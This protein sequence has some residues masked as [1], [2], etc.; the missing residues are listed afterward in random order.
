[1]KG[2]GW[3]VIMLALLGVTYLVV[4]DLDVLTGER[5]GETV[6]EPL[7]HAKDTANLVQKTRDDLQKR[8]DNLDE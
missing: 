1:M 2:V 3:I 4:Q 8:L 6:L 5:G 7:E